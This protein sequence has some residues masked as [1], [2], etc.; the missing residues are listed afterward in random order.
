MSV[1]K[2]QN[3]YVKHDKNQAHNLTV[4]VSKWFQV[5]LGAVLEGVKFEI[6]TQKAQFERFWT[7]LNVFGPRRVP[8]C[9]DGCSCCSY[10]VLLPVFDKCLRLC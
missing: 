7:Q 9:Y 8:K 5:E 10:M 2:K 4:R 1:M 3:E 6:R